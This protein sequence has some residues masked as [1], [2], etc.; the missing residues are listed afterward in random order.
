MARFAQYAMVAA[1]EALGDAGWSPTKGEDLV[2]TV[3]GE[4]VCHVTKLTFVEGVYIGSGIGSLD[5]VYDTTLAYDK[6]V[7]IILQNQKNYP[8]K[9]Q[10]YKK[11]S[12]LFVPRL[13]IN[14]AAGH[15][16]MRFQFKV[17]KP[18]PPY[19]LPVGGVAQTHHRAPITQPRQLVRP[20]PTA[21]ATQ[22][23]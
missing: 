2:Q 5:D 9:P 10:G 14:L 18:P 19:F 15:I 20:A 8:N 11:V 4:S 12:P 7:C 16:S 1:E 13:L 23:A 21:S 3:C 6:G 17:C 22:R